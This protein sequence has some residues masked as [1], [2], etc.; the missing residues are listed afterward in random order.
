MT[1]YDIR[2]ILDQNEE[3]KELLKTTSR[4]Y[5]SKLK[6]EILK[7]HDAKLILKA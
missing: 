3:F 4:N 5:E 6:A 2:F 1:C 7:Y